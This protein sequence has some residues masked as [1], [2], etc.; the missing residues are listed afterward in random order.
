MSNPLHLRSVWNSNVRGLV[1]VCVARELPTRHSKETSS[2]RHAE[3]HRVDPNRF[4]LCSR[5]LMSLFEQGTASTRRL[6]ARSMPKIHHASLNWKV[7]PSLDRDTSNLRLARFPCRRVGNYR[8]MRTSMQKGIRSVA[9][10]IRSSVRNEARR[11]VQMLDV[12]ARRFRPVVLVASQSRVAARR[13]RNADCPR[14]FLPL[15]H[16]LRSG[17]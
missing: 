1:P 15:L 11:R 6:D 17:E 9:R 2:W 7:G 13:V 10:S 16:F 4:A 12:F 8:P 5:F 3:K 14:C